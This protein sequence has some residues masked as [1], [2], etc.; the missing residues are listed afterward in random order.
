ME[1]C[2]NSLDLD[3]SDKFSW[4]FR[5]FFEIKF[6]EIKYKREK[7]TIEKS[8]ITILKF[9]IFILLSLKDNSDFLN[10]LKIL[11]K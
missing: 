7:K 5:F 11:L 10:F 4:L 3:M 1:I 8:K 6:S 2:E 9:K